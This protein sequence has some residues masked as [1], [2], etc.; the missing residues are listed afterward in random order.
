M[1]N[2]VM[3]LPIEESSAMK[4]A[5]GGSTIAEKF[6]ANVNVLLGWYRSN[7]SHS[8]LQYSALGRYYFDKMVHL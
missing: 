8:S 1:K 5:I 4:S 2:K 7:V 3:I 6:N